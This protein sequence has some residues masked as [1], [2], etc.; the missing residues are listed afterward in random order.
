MFVILN[1]YVIRFIFYKIK[2]IN[3]GVS[4]VY[5]LKYGISIDKTQFPN[6][7]ELSVKKLK[8]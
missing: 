4:M 8:S 3:L 2:Y 7:I 6:N 1:F 5:Y